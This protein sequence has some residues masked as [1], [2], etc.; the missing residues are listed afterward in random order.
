MRYSHRISAV[1]LVCIVALFGTGA[2]LA[3]GMVPAAEREPHFPAFTMTREITKEDG[4][5]VYQ[6]EYEDDLNWKLTLLSSP[7][8]HTV[9]GANYSE[10]LRDGE[11]IV[12]VQGEVHSRRKAGRTLI[13]GVGGLWFVNEGWWTPRGSL[14]NHTLATEHRG[15]HRVHALTNNHPNMTSPER[16]TL[17]YHVET[18]IPVGYERHIGEGL[19][20]SHRVT[21][22]VL[23]ATGE[24]LR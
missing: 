12:T 24:K 3:R 10:E 20:E 6:F 23:T 2:L 21:S 9:L 16:T 4:T 22:L 19:V 7:T 8:P 18:G 11:H 1:V 13:P 15:E 17:T 14:S 5:W